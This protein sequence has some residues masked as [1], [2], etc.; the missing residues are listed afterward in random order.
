M[1]AIDGCTPPGDGA[2]VSGLAA[3]VQ[4]EEERVDLQLGEGAFA[5]GWRVVE[6][7]RGSAATSNWKYQSPNGQA[8]TSVR[9]A[10][11]AQ[12]A[13]APIEKG[14]QQIRRWTAWLREIDMNC[15]RVDMCVSKRNDYDGTY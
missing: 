9:H 5:H 1:A 14:A 10:K 8:F 12:Q 2:T 11:L 13:E 3:P 15:M 7:W 6:A 4:W